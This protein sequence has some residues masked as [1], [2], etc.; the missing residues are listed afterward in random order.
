MPGLKNRTFCLGTLVLP[1]AALMV[2]GC[3]QKAVPVENLR[4]LAAVRTAV[5]I[6]SGK[7]IDRCRE[8]VA[9]ELEQGRISGQLA[10][11][12]EAVFQLADGGEWQQA[13][14]LILKIQGR[15]KPDQTTVSGHSHNH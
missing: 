7:Q 2:A 14:K 9:G 10:G 6:Q 3:A 1:V 11:E 12:L 13:E 8:T 15:Y 4:V 5:S